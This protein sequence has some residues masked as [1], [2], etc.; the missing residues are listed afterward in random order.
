MAPWWLSRQHSRSLPSSILRVN[1]EFPWIMDAVPSLTLGTKAQNQAS[2]SQ[3]KLS[4]RCPSSQR[5]FFSGPLSLWPFLVTFPGSSL[6][7]PWTW[8]SSPKV[9]THIPWDECNLS[10]LWPSC[11]DPVPVEKLL[12]WFSP[13][14]W[15][16]PW[17]PG[18]TIH[19]LL[20]HHLYLGW[21]S[22]TLPVQLYVF[23]VALSPWSRFQMNLTEKPCRP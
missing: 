7:S 16:E 21:T 15:P 20:A 5:W 8:P 13:L 11:W 14:S 9:P 12:S 6:F 10:G 23:H 19:H 3:A 1:W 22:L 4:P 18:P 17:C 2:Y